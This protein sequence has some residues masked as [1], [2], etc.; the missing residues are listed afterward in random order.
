MAP[1]SITREAAED[2]IS[3]IEDIMGE[4]FPYPG[5]PGDHSNPGAVWEYSTREA[6]P[7]MSI[8][9]RLKRAKELYG[10]EPRQDAYRQRKAPPIFTVDSLP[11]DGEPEAAD[12]I[13]KLAEQHRKRSE[14]HHAAKL[15]QVRVHMDGPIAIAG[16]GDPHIDDPGCAWGD[17][18]RDVRICR[19]TPG[20][21]AVNIGDSTNN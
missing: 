14:H 3:A 11:S 7:A 5:V 15:R 20:I 13:A 1:P 12:L 4:G 10:I 18:E 8:R 9:S 19:D 6:V 2:L 16:F 17:L 21:M